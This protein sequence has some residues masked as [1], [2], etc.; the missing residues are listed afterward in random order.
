MTF[1]V[2]ESVRD[3]TARVEKLEEDAENVV[4]SL[5]ITRYLALEAVAKAASDVHE[6]P[7]AH[8]HD[9]L[10]RALAALAKT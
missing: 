3:L 5:S 2:E 8:R 4:R 7:T 10:G 1:D 6:C 9:A